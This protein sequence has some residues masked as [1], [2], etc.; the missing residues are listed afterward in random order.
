MAT[1]TISVEDEVEKR[2]RKLASEEYKG[3]KGYLGDAITK[4][5]KK[6]V[7]ENE[8]EERTHRALQRLKKGMYRVGK[9]YTFRREDAYEER[10][11]KQITTR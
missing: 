5:M 3:K 11:R 7:E 6:W 8:V 1:I 9:N 10:L 4:A 2:F